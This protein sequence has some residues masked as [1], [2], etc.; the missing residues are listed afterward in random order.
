[1]ID[2][3][4]RLIVS[5]YEACFRMMWEAIQ[6]CPDDAWDAPVASLA[7]CQAVFH[8]LFFADVYLGPNLESLREQ[9]FHRERPDIFRDY[10]ELENKRQE[11][12]YA[13][14]DTLTYLSICRDKA[15]RVVAGET[16]ATLAGPSGFPWLDRAGLTRAELHVYNIR[17]IHHH[18]AQLSLR[19]RLDGRD[20]V[21]WC[22]AGWDGVPSA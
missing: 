15:A 18:A 14:P 21:P 9:A 12:L 2:L 5:Q 22:K 19:H 10:E 6:R 11:H 16:E 20:G 8:T 7:F 3:Y 1:M 4:Q 17:H 13:R